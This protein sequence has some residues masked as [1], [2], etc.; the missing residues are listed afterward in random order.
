MCNKVLIQ[1]LIASSVKEI[2]GV[3]S[4]VE[5]ETEATR[6]GDKLLPT[7]GGIAAI[8][9]VGATLKEQILH[10]IYVKKLNKRQQ[11]PQIRHQ[12]FFRTTIASHATSRHVQLSYVQI[13]KL[14]KIPLKK[15]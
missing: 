14:I 12:T 1:L 7:N 2:L 9:A 5:W 10:L 3:S 11:L 8:P 6:R 4:F 13:Y 15:F